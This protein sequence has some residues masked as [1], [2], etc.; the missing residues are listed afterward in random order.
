MADDAQSWSKP[1]IDP[2]SCDGVASRGAVILHD[3]FEDPAALA[4]VIVQPCLGCGAPLSLPLR[5]V[6]DDRTAVR[7][8]DAQRAAIVAAYGWLERR[9]GD[10]VGVTTALGLSAYAL[11]VRCDRC[12]AS[13]LAGF[14]YGEVQ[15]ARYLASFDGL[16]LLAR[17]PLRP[18][19]IALGELHLRPLRTDD[20]EAL[21]AYLQEPAVT[22]LTSYPEITRPFVDAMIARAQSRWADGELSKWAL[23]RSDD[24]RLVGTCGFNEWS[25]VHGW[26]EVAFDLAVPQWGR[27]AMSRAVAAVLEVAFEHARVDRVHAYVRVDNA[28]S[29]QLL[30]RAG[31]AHEG[32]LRSFRVCRGQRFDFDLFALLR[33][34]WHARAVP[35]EV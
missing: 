28:R 27:G 23:A 6:L 16:V 21:L 2:S 13:H 32:C 9:L 31:F 29:R 4:R 35:G 22:A 14:G 25:R 3:G 24:D 18:V 1:V 12:G 34:Q 15:P 10:L 26:A 8:R 33:A 11:D 5:T 7:N 19:P 30:Q 20:A 17:G